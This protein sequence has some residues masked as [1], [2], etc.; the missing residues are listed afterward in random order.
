MLQPVNDCYLSPK[1]RRD[2]V[3]VTRPNTC[4]AR[5]EM[6]LCEIPDSF[7]SLYCTLSSLRS[8]RHATLLAH[9]ALRY[10][11]RATERPLRSPRHRAPAPLSRPQGA[12][13]DLSATTRPL[14]SPRHSAPVT[15]IAQQRARYAPCAIARYVPLLALLFA[16]IRA[17][18]FLNAILRDA[19]H[20]SY[21][22]NDKLSRPIQ[23]STQRSH[24]ARIALA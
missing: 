2:E 7:H 10:A 8:M 15:L 22:T 4:S 19:A 16:A 14:R 18:A 23:C 24:S 3:S 17:S 11:L 12:R 9:H 21:S 1:P 20:L 5:A 13:L 6:K